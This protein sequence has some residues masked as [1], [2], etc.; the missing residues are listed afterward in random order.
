MNSSFQDTVHFHCCFARSAVSLPCSL[1]AAQVHHL[2]FVGIFK[3]FFPPEK[4]VSSLKPWDFLLT[5]QDISYSS[6]LFSI[7]CLSVPTPTCPFYMRSLTLFSICLPNHIQKIPSH[8]HLSS[9]YLYS[10]PL[11]LSAE[12]NFQFLFSFWNVLSFHQL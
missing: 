2:M 5:S 1:F 3:Q 12:L 6:L 8:A 10:K 11:H 7:C 9:S 4:F